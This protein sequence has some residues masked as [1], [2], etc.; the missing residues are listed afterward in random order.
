MSSWDCGPCGII[1]ARV[2]I[3]GNLNDLLDVHEVIL[4][5]CER[6]FHDFVDERR[7]LTPHQNLVTQLN[8]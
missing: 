5:R 8:L 6:Q 7:M 3:N 2:L 4:C 1:R